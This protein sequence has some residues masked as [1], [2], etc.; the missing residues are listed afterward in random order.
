MSASL[1]KYYYLVMWLKRVLILAVSIKYKYLFRKSIVI[2]EFGSKLSVGRNFK[3]WNSKI[4]VKGNYNVV[5]ENNCLIDNSILSFYSANGLYESKIGANTRFS[6]VNLQCY[7]SFRCGEYNIFKQL[8][9][10][11][12]LTTF[13]G[14]LI[15]GHHNRFM[16]RFWI[17]YNAKI[18]IGNYNN[19]NEGSWV[20][21]DELIRIGDF[22]QISYNVMIWDSNT[23]NIYEPVLRRELT[24]KHY[25]FFGFENDKPITKPVRI[26][27]DCWIAQNAVI[28]KGTTLN[29]EVIVGFGTFISNKDI[30][31]KTTVVNKIELKLV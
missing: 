23:H 6:D 3:I 26:A 17:R 27:S 13:N 19:I 24:K 15:I 9:Q 28:F 29:D 25:P 30:P 16:N 4:V 7:G 31:Y 1:F 20:R 22:N 18:E 12:M 8:G 2:V 14:S 10:N 11:P 5:I 21:S